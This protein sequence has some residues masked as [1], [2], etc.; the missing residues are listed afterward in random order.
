ME[1]K[2]HPTFKQPERTVRRTLN[3]PNCKLKIW[4]W[5]LFLVKVTVT[6]KD[7]FKHRFSHTLTYDR[8]FDNKGI[9]S[10]ER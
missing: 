2:L 9:K 1:Y 8:E 5:G 7:R 3:N 10:E 4:T 6:T